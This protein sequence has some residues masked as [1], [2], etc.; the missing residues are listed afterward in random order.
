V[1]TSACTTTGSPVAWQLPASFAAVAVTG[2]AWAFFPR[3]RR[4]DVYATTGPGPAAITGQR[5][6]AS[7]ISS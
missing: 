1:I 6:P 7:G 5:T 3:F 4:P 2:V